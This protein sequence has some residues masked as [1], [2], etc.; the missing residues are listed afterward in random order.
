LIENHN[1][2]YGVETI[3]QIMINNEIWIAR[4]RK[5]NTEH[6]EWRERKEHKGEMVQYDGSYHK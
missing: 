3:R 5:N 6:R 4:S 2:V 1:L